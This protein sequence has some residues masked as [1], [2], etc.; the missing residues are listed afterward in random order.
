M[1]EQQTSNGK[2]TPTHYAYQVRKGK[3]KSYWTKIGCA[4]AHK[5][6]GGFNLQL[7]SIP[8]DGSISLRVPSSKK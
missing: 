6:N 2:V 4:F 3:D 5:D 8:T 7:D 1:N